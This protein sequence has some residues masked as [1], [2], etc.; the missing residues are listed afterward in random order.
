[1]DN[2]STTPVTTTRLEE[3]AEEK[4]LWDILT[5]SDFGDWQ[6]VEIEIEPGNEPKPNSTK[7][8]LKGF[9]SQS[10][11]EDDEFQKLKEKLYTSSLKYDTSSKL[12]IRFTPPLHINV[13]SSLSENLLVDSTWLEV[14]SIFLFC[15]HKF[16]NIKINLIK[17]SH[18]LNLFLF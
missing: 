16:Q 6:P 17:I 9:E 1:M 12:I 8:L 14:T 18:K 13:P 11:R 5:G 15:F 7:E 4:Y 2:Q 3:N 10:S